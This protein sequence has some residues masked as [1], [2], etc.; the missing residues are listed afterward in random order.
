[1]N[2]VNRVAVALGLDNTAATLE[3]LQKLE[4]WIGL[5]EIRL[6]LMEE[7]DL[8]QLITRSP[9][10]LV[11]TCR[12]PREGGSFIGTES[13]RL[14]ILSAASALGCAYVDIEWDCVSNFR[15]YGEST[16]VIVSRHFHDSM[17]GDL[18]T[19]YSE[20]RRRADV[21]KLVGFAGQTL[22]TLPIIE[23][24]VKADSP[25]IAI[26]MGAAGLITRLIAPCFD[27]CLLTYAAANPEAGTA[28]GQIG[29]HEM[30]N[31]FGVDRVGS[32]TP[33]E[34]H[35]YCDPRKE[36]AAKEICRGDGARLHVPARV[37]RG[38]IGLL[39]GALE[40]LTP[41]ISVSL[42]ETD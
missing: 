39:R 13:E 8:E 27:S 18:W 36:S 30:I 16:K 10:P 31:H 29:V 23:L 14:E 15:N 4:G 32:D 2:P 37:G 3:E 25:V 28:P 5:A 38:H 9:C 1:L 41:R 11:V 20:M 6:D 22:D 17:P 34:V 40:G 19:Q 35:L 24:M 7:F 42:F 21:V 33:I 12:A 26:A